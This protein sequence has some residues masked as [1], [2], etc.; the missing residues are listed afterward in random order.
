MTHENSF[1][2]SITDL[3]HL[4]HTCMEYSEHRFGVSISR[5]PWE[6][7]KAGVVGFLGMTL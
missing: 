1:C 4:V 7:V 2:Y 5:I 3:A 6:I